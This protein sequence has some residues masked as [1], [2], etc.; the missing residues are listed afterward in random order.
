MPQPPQ[1]AQQVSP[2]ARAPVRAGASSSSQMSDGTEQTSGCFVCSLIPPL[3]SRSFKTFC[4]C[5]A[6]SKG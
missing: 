5:L 1:G 4:Q 3:V 6:A 2:A